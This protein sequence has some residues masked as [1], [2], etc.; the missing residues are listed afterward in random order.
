MKSLCIIV[1]TNL[2]DQN[3]E[4]FGVDIFKSHYKI[5]VIDCS[6]LISRNLINKFLRIDGRYIYYEIDSI[7]SLVN[8][9]AKISPEF[10]LD[11]SASSELNKLIPMLCEDL[12]ILSVVKIAGSI[13][14]PRLHIRVINFLLGR[15]R[16]NKFNIKIIY[17]K[18]L[19]NIHSIFLSNSSY[20]HDIVLVS[21]SVSTPFKKNIRGKIIQIASDDFHFAK[22]NQLQFNHPRKYVV[23]IDDCLPLADDWN[24]LNLKSPVNKNSYYTAL[25]HFLNEFSV[26]F[27]LDIIIAGHPNS[28]QIL[29]FQDNFNFPVIYDHTSSLVKSCDGV[30]SHA[31][32]AVS[33]AVIFKK[34]IFFITTNDIKKS[35]YNS[36]ID[37]FSNYFH[38]K[39][40]NIDSFKFNDLN[41]FSI[42]INIYN[43]YINDYIIK[44]GYIEH[45][46]WG[47]F[48][49]Y[50]NNK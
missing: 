16:Q 18:I 23:F 8:L 33:F 44:N 28:K 47:N 43:K 19:N 25:N 22:N 10:L 35:F 50:L 42:D 48:I 41:N 14:S 17:N 11:F 6:K 40:I 5:N 39:P 7:D 37:E 13:P 2:T 20:R 26:Y 4:R 12:G 31:S 38:V 27:N 29:K 49:K 45:T 34:P 36:F 24:T 3:L 30:I 1:G 46:Y 32:T 15:Y 21:G 9:L